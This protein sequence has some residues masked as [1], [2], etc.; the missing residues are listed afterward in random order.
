[1]VAT[2][3]VRHLWSRP[4]S[5]S[6]GFWR[7]LEGVFYGEFYNLKKNQNKS[8]NSDRMMDRM[9]LFKLCVLILN[10][11]VIKFYLEKNI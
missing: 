3:V 5:E 11:L 10:I 2:A 7:R 6:L 1:M 9:Q 8:L 4:T